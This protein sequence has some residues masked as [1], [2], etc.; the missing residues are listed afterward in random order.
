MATEAV[1]RAAVERAIETATVDPDAPV[2]PRD[3]R[4]SFDPE[5]LSAVL[6]HCTTARQTDAVLDVVDAALR[7]AIEA[8]D[9]DRTLAG[10]TLVARIQAGTD[11]RQVPVE[12]LQGDVGTGLGVPW[13][14]DP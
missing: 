8:L 2:E 7:E 10:M 3:E 1:I 14:E 13:Q 5:A 6:R 12:N 9:R 11:R 4:C